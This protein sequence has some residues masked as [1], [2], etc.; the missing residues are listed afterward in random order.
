MRQRFEKR[1]LP[2]RWLAGLLAASLLPALAHDSGMSHE[3]IQPLAAPAYLN[4]DKV[5]LGERLFMDSR[6]GRDGDMA[7]AS[8]HFLHEHGADHEPRALGRGGERLDFNTPTVF[9]SGFNYRQFWDG[10]AGSLEEQIDF[11]VAGEKEFATTWPA[12]VT[13]LEQDRDYRRDFRRLYE[14]GIT[15]A[16][17]R[18]AIATFERSLVTVDAP[19]DRYL[20]G[21]ERAIGAQAR[22]GYRLFKEYGCSACHQGRNVGGNLFVKFGVFKDILAT[23]PQP[24]RADLGRFNVTGK[25]EDR[26]VFRVPSLR[27]AVLTAPYFHDGSVGTLAEA[28]RIMAEYQL[29]RSIPE[30]DVAAIEAFLTTLVGEYR[31]RSLLDGRRAGGKAGGP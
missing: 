9:N 11:V 7:C 2:A 26:H 24:R 10:R 6:L 16:N 13:R 19:F 28:I 25:A 31:G 27:L 8:C 15:A 5:A 30:D 21:D 4:G 20:Q 3:P 22:R 14:D 29:G 1:P 23:R 18:D 12:I 17:V